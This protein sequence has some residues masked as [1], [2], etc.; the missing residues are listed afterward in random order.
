MIVIVTP[1]LVKPLDLARQ[2]L[3]TDA[4]VE[5]DDLEFYLLGRLEGREK[6]KAAQPPGSSSN[7]RKE[8]A[9]EGK[10]GHILQK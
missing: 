6:P 10:F 4:Y 2:T 1:H 8:W 7:S 9:L 3:P 5:P